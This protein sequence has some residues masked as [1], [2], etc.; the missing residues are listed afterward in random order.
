MNNL[1]H[2]KT[3]LPGHYS[4]AAPC[5]VFM[6]RKELLSHSHSSKKTYHISL[7]IS[8]TD[9]QF[10]PGDSIGILPQN[11]PI[12]IWRFFSLLTSQ[13]TDMMKDPRSQE[14]MSAEHYLLS[15]VNLSRVNTPLLRHLFEK[16]KDPILASL[17][18]PENKSKLTE[19]LHGK[20]LI[21]ILKLFQK[22]LSSLEEIAPFFTPLLPRFYS[23]SSSLKAQRQKVDLLVALSSYLHGEELRYGV[24]SHFL[25]NLAVEKQ[26]KIPLYIQPSIHFRLPEDTSQNLIMIGPG[27]GVAPY[28]AFLQERMQEN[29]SGK[30]WLFFGERTKEHDFTYKNYLTSLEAQGK[31]KLDLAFSRDQEEKIYVQHKLLAKAP[32]V[33]KWMT[34][35][36]CLYVCGDAHKMAKDV[37]AALLYIM[38]TQGGL[39]EIESKAHLKALRASKKYMTDLY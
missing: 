36:A 25:C 2:S 19:F 16:T 11:D 21:D 17:L 27:T 35:G 7:D 4:K 18:E 10:Y 6:Q 30:H 33:W 29:A 38:H 26:T 5:I 14:E 34:E 15:K 22:E 31:L 39:S 12:L 37:E 9:L 28:R 13:P 32:E 1:E 8:N 3:P 23:I 24:A 20:D